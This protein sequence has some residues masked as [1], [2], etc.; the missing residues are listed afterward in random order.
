LFGINEL[1]TTRNRVLEASSCNRLA[2]KRG[3]LR[4]NYFLCLFKAVPTIGPLAERGVSRFRV[5]FATGSSVTEIGFTDCVADADKH[6]RR[7]T[8]AKRLQKQVYA[9]Y[10]Q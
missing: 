5:A 3:A 8:P 10:S 7:I 6:G 2:G 4:L 1:R 9:N